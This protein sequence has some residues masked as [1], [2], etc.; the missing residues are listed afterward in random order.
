M[1]KSMHSLLKAFTEGFD[2]MDKAKTDEVNELT[3]QNEERQKKRVRKLDKIHSSISNLE[4]L[5]SKLKLSFNDEKNL[6]DKNE[7]NLNIQ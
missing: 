1:A 3:I 6:N 4:Q 7:M 2:A 5:T